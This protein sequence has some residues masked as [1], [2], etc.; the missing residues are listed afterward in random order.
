LLGVGGIGD[1][2]VLGVGVL[3]KPLA[4]LDLVQLA[5][6]RGQLLAV[7][8]A[9]DPQQAPHLV[10][11]LALRV[12]A[13]LDLAQL[14]LGDGHA[15]EVGEGH[16]EL[17]HA[18]GRD[19]QVGDRLERGQVDRRRVVA[20]GKELLLGRLD[21]RPVLGGELG[22]LL[23]RGLQLGHLCTSKRA[24]CT[25]KRAGESTAQGPARL[26]PHPHQRARLLF[27]SVGPRC[28]L[29]RVLVLDRE[30]AEPSLRLCCP[31]LCV[32][33]SSV[34]E[35]GGLYSPL[36]LG[37]PLLGHTQLLLESALPLE[38]RAV[39]RRAEPLERR[40]LLG[41]LLLQC[42]CLLLCLPPCRLELPHLLGGLSPGD[43]V[44][45][46]RLACGAPLRL[47]AQRTLA[48]QHHRG[49]QPAPARLLRVAE[50]LL[51]ERVVA[52]LLHHRF[53]G[54][55]VVQQPAPELVELRPRAFGGLQCALRLPQCA[56]RLPLRALQLLLLG[57]DRDAR[58]VEL[59]LRQLPPT[60][61]EPQVKAER[62]DLLGQRSSEP[63]G[64]AQL[65][66][67]R[68]EP[69]HVV[70]PAQPMHARLQPEPMVRAHRERG[71]AIRA[72]LQ[73]SVGGIGGWRRGRGGGDA[74]GASSAFLDSR[75]AGC[76]AGCRGPQVLVRRRSE[77]AAAQPLQHRV[78]SSFLCLAPRLVSVR[79]EC[80]RHLLGRT[81]SWRAAARLRAC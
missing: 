43:L 19:A 46:L 54:G 35:V 67:R 76:I 78:V 9:R 70:Q 22:L 47:L 30:L 13:R 68:D 64:R 36:V 33:R 72:A 29:Q 1:V 28:T 53:P 71:A 77:D 58:P 10:G 34:G 5:A 44:G 49:L 26:P 73:L 8:L 21:H 56:L 65:R 23:E 63:L 7:G 12:V 20:V 17:R 38:R 52:I 41:G 60:M 62:R 50:P 37:A 81:Q 57:R 25:S 79:E 39:A 24:G 2:A 45:I 27:E 15:V 42:C 66:V 40:L 3:Q 14:G 4:G 11:A 59:L 69:E 31:P 48:P 18:A 51:L 75:V 16:E 32:A 74:P 80:F 55:A 61:L 6:D